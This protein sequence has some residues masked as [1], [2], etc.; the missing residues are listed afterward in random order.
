MTFLTD[1]ELAQIRLD[2]DEFLTDTCR[3]ERPTI[4]NVNG[5]ASKAWG[6][7]V[8]SAPCRFDPDTMRK[9]TQIIGEREADIAPYIVTLEHDVDIQDGDRLIYSGGTYHITS[10]AE[11]HSARF[12]TR[13]RCALIRGE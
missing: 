10:L 5:Y 7:V 1:A 11:K 12:T 13:V 8:A 4:T 6:T 2:L 3:I 9:D